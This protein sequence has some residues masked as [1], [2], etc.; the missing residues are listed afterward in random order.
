MTAFDKALK[1]TLN[2]EGGISN[3]PV[4]RGGLTAHGIT[5]QTYNRFRRLNALSPRSVI[6]IAEVEVTAIYH[7]EYWKAAHCH[8][9]PERLALCTFDTA[10]N[11]GPG[12]AIRLLQSALRVPADGQFGPRTKAAVDRADEFETIRRFLDAR[13]D[14]YDDIIES[15]PS[16]VRFRR[17]WA[18]RVVAL[19][20]TLLRDISGIA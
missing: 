19:R 12:R 9:M 5:Q 3:D 20:E 18:N 15:D 16:Q 6:H 4:D 10:V 8:E 11:M 1:L 13:Q 2:F 17:G 7:T 14:F